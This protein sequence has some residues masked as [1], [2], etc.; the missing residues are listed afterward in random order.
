MLMTALAMIIGMVPMALGLGE[1]GEQNAPLGRAVIGGLIFATISTLFWC[2]SSTHCCG[3]GRRPCTVSTRVSRPRRQARKVRGML[4]MARRGCFRSFPVSLDRIAGHRR[5]GI[6]RRSPVAGQGCTAGASREAMAEGLAKG[7]TI[8]VATIAQGPKERLITLLGDTRPYQ[9][10]DVVREGRRR[11][12]SIAV[13]RGD[14][15]KT[16]E[17]VAEAESAETD[18]QSMPRS[19]ISRTRRRMPSGNAIWCRAAGPRC[20][21]RTKRTPRIA[22]RNWPCS[23]SW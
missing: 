16:G 12:E 5:R 17:M 18:R 11:S 23:N 20:R 13:D 1:A 21:R 3:A 6:H 8:Q 7:P 9:V 15:V 22:W 14:R 2:R 19:A 4:I 10:A